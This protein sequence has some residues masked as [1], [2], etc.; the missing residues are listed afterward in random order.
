MERQVL[1][2]SGFFGGQQIIR[3]KDNGLEFGEGEPLRIGK[4]LRNLSKRL[5]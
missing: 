4:Q 3:H 1:D 2:E 5:I